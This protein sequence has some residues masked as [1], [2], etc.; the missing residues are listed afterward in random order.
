MLTETSLFGMSTGTTLSTFCCHHI[1]WAIASAHG[2]CCL[3][4]MSLWLAHLG[5]Q[6]FR[7]YS[8]QKKNIFEILL[9]WRTQ[10]L[11]VRTEM[12][13]GLDDKWFCHYRR[14][15][16]MCTGRTPWHIDGQN[17]LACRRRQ[18]QGCWRRILACRQTP[19]FWH[20][21][22]HSVGI[23]TERVFFGMSTEIFFCMST[24]AIFL[25]C[26]RRQSCLACRR[27]QSFLHVDGDNLVFGISTGTTLLACQRRQS[28]L[29]C[30]R[31]HFFACRRR[32]SFLHVDGDNLFCMWTETILFWH[33]DGDNPFGMSTVV[34][35][36]LTRRI[37]YIY[38]YI[39]VWCICNIERERVVC[40]CVWHTN[41]I[42]KW[43]VYDVYISIA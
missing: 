10:P 41:L 25:A 37:P 43:C 5:W 15:F 32:Q 1:N 24:G 17:P 22:D 7:C 38:I 35:G 28:P 42:C 3:S 34:F 27:R 40:L 4:N 29:A 13:H 20:I 8:R 18:L 19:S 11:S 30:R 2:T 39:C 14:W 9:L 6:H 23:S 36:M 31:E 16:G 26:R 21:D 12:A 33:V